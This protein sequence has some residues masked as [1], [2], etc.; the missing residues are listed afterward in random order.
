MIIL[1]YK[2]LYNFLETNSYRLLEK[3]IIRNMDLEEDWRNIRNALMFLQRFRYLHRLMVAA[4]DHIR[5]ENLTHIALRMNLGLNGQLE[6]KT[7]L[8]KQFVLH[9]KNAW[10][11]IQKL[12]R[13]IPQ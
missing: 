3:F 9:R 5:K 11:S 6:N 12:I 2:V 13:N 4:E 1:V 7:S 10:R 8:W